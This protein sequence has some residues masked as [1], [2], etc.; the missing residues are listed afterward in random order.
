MTE[1]QWMASSDPDAMLSALVTP[2]V[3][4]DLFSRLYPLERRI[5]LYA[6]A[7]CRRVRGLMSHAG[8]RAAVEHAEYMAE[9]GRR[10]PR[11]DHRR[12]AE[13]AID[14]CTDLASRRAA[15]AALTASHLRMIRPMEMAFPFYPGPNPPIQPEEVFGYAAKT[16]NHCRCAVG[17]SAV[18]AE[19]KETLLAEQAAQASLLRDVIGNPFRPRPTLD[20]AWLR[21][22]DGT[23]ARLARGIYEERRFQDMPILHDALLDSGCDNQDIL[24]HCEGPGP[25]VR[26][27]W[28]LDL[29]LGKE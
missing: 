22:N 5:R 2:D 11:E 16:A 25:H 28:V 8:S 26:G 27:C 14:A 24:D 21:W 29:L 7:C 19:G 3:C 4:D 18:P 15:S 13:G 20:P 9:E 23:V 17:L 12:A 10:D 1:Q 6:V